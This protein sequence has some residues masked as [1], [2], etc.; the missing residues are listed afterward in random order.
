VSC[1]LADNNLTNFTADFYAAVGKLCLLLPLIINKD[2]P[3]L[4]GASIMS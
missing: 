4:L 2:F 3:T 1:L